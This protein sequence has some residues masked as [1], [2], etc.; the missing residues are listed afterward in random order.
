MGERAKSA[1]INKRFVNVQ[2]TVMHK[3]LL[4][5]IRGTLVPALLL[6]KQEAL[7][8]ANAAITSRKPKGQLSLAAFPDPI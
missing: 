1:A 6:H 2:A 7:S 8:E 5:T 3:Q 4:G